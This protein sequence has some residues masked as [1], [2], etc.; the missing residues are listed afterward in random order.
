MASHLFIEALTPAEADKVW[1]ILVEEVGANPDK[2]GWMYS[3]FMRYVTVSEG[4]F[5]H[6][7]RFQGSLG[8]GGKF[9]NGAGPGWRVTCYPES[10]TPERRAAIDEAN[11]RLQDEYDLAVY[12]RKT[13]AK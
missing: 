2:T 10:E 4:P 7:F 11:R 12:R 9:L 3:A 8:F 13:A 1:D 5:S 6:E